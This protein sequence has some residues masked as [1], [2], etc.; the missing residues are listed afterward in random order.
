MRFYR[1]KLIVAAAIA[2]L[3]ILAGCKDHPAPNEG[4]LGKQSSSP[5]VSTFPVSADGRVDSA[6]IAELAFE[7]DSINFGTVAEGEVVSRRFHFRNTGQRALVIGDA[8]SSCGCTVSDYP[9][10]PVES[11]DT[12]SV[13][14]HFDTEGRVGP[15]VK[16]VTLTANT[17]PSTTSL[18]LRGVV[19]GN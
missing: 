19:T 12:A 18:T 9:Q 14:V 3:T 7:T 10:Q 4:Q 6:Q 11:G 15:Q 17:Y 16:A 8:R 13:F 5:S 1:G 2:A